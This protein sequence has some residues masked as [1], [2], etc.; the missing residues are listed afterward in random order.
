MAAVLVLTCTTMASAEDGHSEHAHGT[1]IPGLALNDKAKWKADEHTLESVRDMQRFLDDFESDKLELSDYSSL[2]SKLQQELDALIV[3]CTM[4]GPAHE[5]LHSWIS[6][7]AP[8][9]RK[10]GEDSSNSSQKEAYTRVK[11]LL[12]AFERRFH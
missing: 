2:A 4:Q 3:G 12:L 6:S 1:S 7:F 5:Q 8:A 11:E 10:L 9:I